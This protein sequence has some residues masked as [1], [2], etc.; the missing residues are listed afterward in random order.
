M[1]NWGL[2]TCRQAEGLYY[3]KR[4][5]ISQKH[6]VQ[7]VI[8]HEVAHQW[9][10]NLVTMKWWNNL[11]LNEGFATMISYRA[12]DFLEN[13]TYRYQDMT[14]NMMCQV[15]RTDQNEASISVSS[16]GD[17]EV[18]KI[19]TQRVIIYRKAAIITRMIERLV[20]ED[21]FQK[22]LHRFLNTF[23]YKNA[24]HD[25]LFNVLTYVHDSSS[26]GHLTGQNFSLSDVMDTWLRQASF[27]VVHVNRKEGSVVTLRQE[28]YKHNPRAKKNA[29]DSYVWKIPIFYDDPVSGSHKVFWITDRYPVVFDMVGEVLI[30]P[31]QLTYMRVRYDM[32]M[33]SDITMKLISNHESIPINSRSRLIDDTLAMAENQQISYQVP[34]NMTLYLP[35]EV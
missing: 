27:P 16:K 9:F 18:Q 35:N 17:E 23:M 1:E 3:P 11:W 26:G 34:F 28:R 13:T 8:S 33:Y 21:I 31:H 2:I 19:I 20:Q 25:D 6:N 14:S 30:D 7:E 12:V 24:D 22:G 10:G 5:P 15:L 32:S 29:K 4:F